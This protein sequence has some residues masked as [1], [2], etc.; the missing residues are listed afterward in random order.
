MEEKNKKEN[1]EEEAMEL[2]LD[3]LDQVS[4][5]ALKN[6][7]VQKTKDITDSVAQRIQ[8]KQTI[9]RTSGFWFGGAHIVLLWNVIFERKGI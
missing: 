5:G 4:G 6:A 7:K 9:E 2:D 3:E 1:V 8:L